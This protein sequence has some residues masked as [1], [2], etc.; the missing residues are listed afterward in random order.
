MIALWESWAQLFST[1]KL[2]NTAIRYEHDKQKHMRSA[3]PDGD[4]RSI[5]VSGQGTEK[6]NDPEDE[7][8]RRVKEDPP[9]SEPKKKPD[10]CSAHHE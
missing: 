8:N 7:E 4:V 1:T 2:L 5:F 6:A 10:R 9:R 3:D